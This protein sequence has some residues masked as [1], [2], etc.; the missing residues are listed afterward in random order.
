MASSLSG[1]FQTLSQHLGVY[2]YFALVPSHAHTFKNGFDKYAKPKTCIWLSSKAVRVFVKPWNHEPQ[3]SKTWQARL[4]SA[5][6]KMLVKEAAGGEK[7]VMRLT[8]LWVAEK[9]WN[10]SLCT[11]AL[12]LK[13]Y[14]NAAWTLLR[15]L[16]LEVTVSH[17]LSY[18]LLFSMKRWHRLRNLK[19]LA[20]LLCHLFTLLLCHSPAKHDMQL[21]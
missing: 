7:D 8:T 5:Y 21:F 10:Q 17:K 2:M 18:I 19:Y 1:A 14:F 9:N 3:A 11:K 15:L 13:F 20:W 16:A 6:N 12:W 4:Q